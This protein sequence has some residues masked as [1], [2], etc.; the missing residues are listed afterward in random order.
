[1]A[2]AIV[3]SENRLLGAQ[4]KRTLSEQRRSNHLHRK[5]HVKDA[6]QEVKSMVR[7]DDIAGGVWELLQHQRIIFESFDK[8]IQKIIQV[9]EEIP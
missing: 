2:C 9:C 1:M 3:S 6:K 7:F 8:H 5:L 4:V